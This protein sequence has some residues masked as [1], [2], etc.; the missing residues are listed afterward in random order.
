MQ[1]IEKECRDFLRYAKLERGLSQNT[2][3]SY[4]HDLNIYS[5]FAMDYGCSCIG[6]I[7]YEHI[8]D[9]LIQLTELSLSE[10]TRNRYLAA[11]R[12]IHSYLF[13]DN[14]ISSD[15]T[16][17]I[18]LPRINRKI[19]DVMSVETIDSII[20]SI[21]IST[22]AGIRDRAIIEVLYACGLRVSELIN[23]TAASILYEE[24]IIRVTGKGNKER[25]IPIGQ[26]ALLWLDKYILGVRPLFYSSKTSTEIFL[27]QRGG[28][29]SRMAIWNIINKYS[30]MVDVP[31][32][33]HPHSF[34]HSFATHLLEGGAD[35]R[36][37][38]ELL[39][40]SCINTTQIYTHIDMSYLKEVHRSFHP[41][42]I[43]QQHL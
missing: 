42:A 5:K 38:Q 37:I 31:F 40:H 11:V 18:E 12:G 41:R 29:L 39:G 26:E 8:T 16:E 6:E 15:V 3:D 21:D 9:F 1:Q 30:K 4:T 25:I 14:K 22:P 19:P 2:I 35:L 43:R 28:K 36:V 33:V 34:R 24:D 32:Q 27:N 13:A 23:L 7:T 20:N 10:A 17:L